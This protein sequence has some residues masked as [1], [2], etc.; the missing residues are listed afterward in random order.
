MAIQITIRHIPEKVRDELAARAALRGKSM[1]EYLREELER[2]AAR[3]S[4]EAWLEQVRRRKR[5][6]QTRVTG[7][8]ILKERDADRR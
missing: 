5:A 4:V 1:Q 3:P 2:L 8:Q 6:S 7:G